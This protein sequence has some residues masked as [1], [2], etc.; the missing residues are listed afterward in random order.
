MTLHF[1]DL[2][3]EAD[4]SL[5]MAS[6]S[7]RR[8]VLIHTA[9]SLGASLVI[10][11]LNL[12]FAQMIANT[13]GLGGVGT[14][15]MLQTAQTMLELA[16]TAALPFWNISLIRASLCW[17]RGERAEFPTLL[18]GFRRFR[19]VL[20]LKFLTL[21]LF[22]ILWFALSQVGTT[23]F[24]LSPFSKGFMEAME[25]IMQESGFFDP[26]TLMDE[27]FMTQYIS[28]AKP[29]LIFYGVVF[30]IAA[31][32]VWYRIRFADFAVM[33]G[34]R[35][36]F[37][38]LQSFR[39]TRKHSLEMFRI[40]L[41]F[42]WFYLLQ[43]FTVV[44]CYGDTILPALG[45]RLPMSD[46]VSYV[47]FYATGILLQGLLLWWYQAKVS[48]VYALAYETLTANSERKVESC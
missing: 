33:D 27:A 22:M 10:G 46:A 1:A 24:M 48:T 43:I 45:I 34:N 4:R 26:E 17:A 19:S 28:A 11:L 39:I 31:V 3:R 30:L 8:L 2:R 38:L 42:W 23:L 13:G 15:S 7:P 32:I 12:L 5:A 18:E 41:R 21:A 20:G 25:P 47:V 6:Y 29:L 40:D 44:L 35:S 14:R 36:F 16:V 9:V 37:S